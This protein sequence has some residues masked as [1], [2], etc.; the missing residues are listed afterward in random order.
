MYD[1]YPVGKYHYKRLPMVV[2]NSPD[3]FQKKITN[4]LHG[5]EFIHA[6]VDDLLIWTKIDWTDHVKKL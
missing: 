5:F 2:A 3:L 1:Y 4:L 6:N